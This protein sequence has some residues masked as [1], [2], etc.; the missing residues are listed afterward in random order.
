MQEIF[1]YT[2]IGRSTRIGGKFGRPNVNK[3]Y[4]GEMSLRQEY[5]AS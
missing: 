5:N 2:G 4:K 3:V 1:E